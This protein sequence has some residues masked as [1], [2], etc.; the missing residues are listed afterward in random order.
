M[1]EREVRALM[2]DIRRSHG[3]DA[4]RR[5]GDALRGLARRGEDRGRRRDEAE[6][7][8]HRAR[9]AARRFADDDEPGEEAAA[10]LVEQLVEEYPEIGHVIREA[11]EDRRGPSHW[12]RDRRLSRDAMRSFR[13]RRL[14]RDFGPESMTS[15]TSPNIENFAERR[16]QSYR[17]ETTGLDRRRAHDMAYD[18]ASAHDTFARLFGHQAASIITR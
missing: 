1:N 10:E 14:G 3:E 5:V 9:D 17:E 6:D 11:A 7:R 16:G 15:S 13:P 18:A 8:H 12:A 4:G 2:E